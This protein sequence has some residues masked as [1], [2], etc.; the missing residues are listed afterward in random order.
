MKNL[1]TLLSV[2]AALM[3]LLSLAVPVAFADEDTV[4]GSFTAANVLPDVTALE[5]YSDA[6]LT[7][8]A[9]NLN[10]Y[11]E[12]Y[13]KVTAGDLNTI[14][15]IDEIEAQLFYDSAGNDPNAPGSADTQTCAILTWDKDGGS[16][17]TISAGAGTTWALTEGDCVKPSDMTASSDYW[18]FAVTIGKVATESPGSDDWD[19]YA[20]ATDAGGNDEMY[21]VDKEMMWYGEIMANTTTANF[22]SVTPGTGFTDG[23]NEVD[24][25]SM[26]Y[27][28]NGDYDQKV[29]SAASWSGTTYTAN[30]D[31]SGTCD[32]D[33]E[34][35]LM[36]Y[37][38]DTFGSAVQVDTTGVSIDATGTQTAEAGNTVAANALWMK[39]GDFQID[40]YSGNVTYI[41]E[42]R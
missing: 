36:A 33:Q 10:P 25:I 31:D 38:E 8:T 20:K 30:F 42:D 14:D 6:G 37:D 3:L 7:S 15:D 34:F 35:S 32:D 4:D 11:V 2:A 29:K 27:I 26:N 17:W 41:I 40:T 13:V 19:V 1:K 16:E 21:T 24:D 5:V 22:G 9:S 18:V 23:I 28:A 39:V 12:Y